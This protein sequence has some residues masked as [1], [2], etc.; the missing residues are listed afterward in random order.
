MYEWMGLW[1]NGWIGG[2]IIK[3]SIDKPVYYLPLM[4]K[5]FLVIFLVDQEWN[6]DE[7]DYTMQST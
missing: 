4:S 1:T 6:D 5:M 3:Q 7:D 2:W